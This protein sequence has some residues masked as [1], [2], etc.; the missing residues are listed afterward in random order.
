MSLSRSFDAC[1]FK[2]GVTEV[3]VM[4][5]GVVQ[6]REDI[7]I[8]VGEQACARKSHIRGAEIILLY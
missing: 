8:R 1:A 7:R 3:R 2:I 5:D 4:A 6:D